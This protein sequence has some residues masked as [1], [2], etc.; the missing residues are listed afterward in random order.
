MNIYIESRHILALGFFLLAGSNAYGQ[1]TVTKPADSRKKDLSSSDLHLD[2]SLSLFDSLSLFQSGKMSSGFAHGHGLRVVDTYSDDERSTTILK[3]TYGGFDFCDHSIKIHKWAD[4]RYLQLGTAPEISDSTSEDH[5]LVWSDE[6]SIRARLNEATGSENIISMKKCL[7]PVS[8]IPVPVWEILYES[9]KLH[10]K[11]QLDER[12]VYSFGNQYFHVDG[13]ATIYSKNSTDGTLEEYSL[14]NLVGSTYLN[15]DKFSAIL[16]SNSTETRATSST[17]NF[18]FDPS[19]SAFAQTS[20]FTN[21]TRALAWFESIGYEKFSLKMALVV[22]AILNNN[23]NNALYQPSTTTPTIYVGDGDGTILQNLAT[24]LDVVFHEFGHHVIYHTLTTT[25]GESLVLHEGIAD[26]F[27]FAHTEDACL[28]ESI[29][30]SE[31]PIGCAVEAKCL[32]SAENSFQYGGSDL[33]AEEHLKSQFISGMLWDLH[34][35]DGLTLDYVARLTLT[36]IGFLA[37][38][39]GYHDL[40]LALLYADGEL[41]SSQNC[42]T[43][44]S[45]AQE[46]GLSNVISDFDCSQVGSLPIIEGGQTTSTTTSTSA[47]SKDDGS[48]N[49]FCGISSTAKNQYSLLLLLIPLTLLF[50]RRES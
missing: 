25:K 36:G 41:N 24:D 11:I 28:G 42:S 8:Q 44:Y 29:C 20:I 46:R 22:H 32:R 40:V 1:P 14:L 49:P 30:P 16:D 3:P 4:G 35:K 18:T 6:Q 15:N 47:S 23:S 19:T 9:N 2:S 38:N 50:R 5:N 33:P 27:T 26:F 39:S 21:A 10:H 34:A 7:V 43:I 31:S 45:R 37:N 13:K 17:H 12:D 48:T